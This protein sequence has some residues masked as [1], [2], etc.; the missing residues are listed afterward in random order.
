VLVD[1]AEQRRTEVLEQRLQEAL[2][3]RAM[4]QIVGD[5]MGEVIVA[6]LPQTL[7]FRI[8]AWRLVGISSAAFRSATP[9][10]SSTLTPR[11]VPRMTQL[12]LFGRLTSLSMWTPHRVK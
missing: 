5:G 2:I 12:G 7:S 10:L 6:V 3:A 11:T 9:V 1:L 8:S 4:F